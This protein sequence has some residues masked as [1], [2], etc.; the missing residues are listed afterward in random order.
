LAVP[1]NALLA[2]ADGSYAVEIDSGGR[3]RVVPV[4]TGLFDEDG[5]IVEISGTD[6]TAGTRVLVPQ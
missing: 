3:R 4:Q 5:G 2:L 1:V 6:I